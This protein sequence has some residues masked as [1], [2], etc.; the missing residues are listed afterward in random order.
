MNRIKA[1]FA[2]L[3]ISMMVVGIALAVVYLIWYP[4]PF[5]DT[6]D[7]WSMVKILI[8]VDLVL[9]PMVT[10]I[11]FNTRKKSRNELKRDLSIIATVQMLALG[12]GMYSMFDQRP[13]YLVFG[14]DRFEVMTDDRV[15]KSPLPE[16]L[17]E[18]LLGGPLVVYAHSGSTDEEKRKLIRE[19]MAGKGDFTTRREYYRPVLDYV[20]NIQQR[21]I[22][23]LKIITLPANVSKT[24]AIAEVKQHVAS[25]GSDRIYLPLVGKSRS[26]V[27]AFDTATGEVGPV[28]NLYPFEDKQPVSETGRKPEQSFVSD[29]ESE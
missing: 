14:V 23:P 27:T 11:I 17:K 10:L 18:G 16:G 28:F 26:M 15:D 24:R 19:W 9:G 25:H 3:L 1:S 2:H 21:Q 5:G 29:A 7:I 4:A 12:Y 13:D 20:Q 8:G 22:D 6:N